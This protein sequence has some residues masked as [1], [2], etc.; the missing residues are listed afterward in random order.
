MEVALQLY[1]YSVVNFTPDRLRD[2]SVNLGI[3]VIDDSG[4]VRT[5][6]LRRFATRLRNLDPYVDIPTIR[7]YLDS[8]SEDLSPQVSMDSQFEKTTVR[9]LSHLAGS[10]RNQI[11]ISEPKAYRATTMYEATSR[12]FAELVSPQH[13]PPTP[14]KGMNLRR[15][16][17]L[18]RQTI[19]EWSTET[20]RIDESGLARGSAAH[21]FADFWI[22]S[23][24]PMAALLAIPDDPDEK[25][26]AW[27]R[28][29]SVPTIAEEFNE[30]ND[31]FKTIVV[32]PPNG[33]SPPLDF[34][35]ETRNL[36][37]RVSGV[38]VTHVDELPDL[39]ETIEHRL[40]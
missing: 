33:H 9:R 21:H 1:H 22:Q 4:E 35:V 24:M 12:L 2:E 19:R 3:I 39:R 26:I 34:V 11:R 28:R 14:A 15:L 31:N 13:K 27:A 8:L 5:E 40:L 10:L 30:L 7:D 25:D 18:I 37:E 38:I 23:G 6:F 20:V 32:F 29:D 17:S 16:R 36:L